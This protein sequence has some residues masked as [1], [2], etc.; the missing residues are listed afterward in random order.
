MITLRTGPSVV[1][2]VDVAAISGEE[3]E[4]ERGGLALRKGEGLELRERERREKEG[5]CY[6]IRSIC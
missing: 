4:R 3:R 1:S 5:H 2:E 6:L